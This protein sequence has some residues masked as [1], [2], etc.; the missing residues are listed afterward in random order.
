VTRSW[1]WQPN[2]RIKSKSFIAFKLGA[3]K[4]AV[5]RKVSPGSRGSFA[6]SVPKSEVLS[7]V[8][9]AAEADWTA[10]TWLHP[11]LQRICSHPPSFL[12]FRLDAL[13][14]Y[15]LLIKIVLV[16]PNSSPKLIYLMSTYTMDFSMDFS[17]QILHDFLVCPYNSRVSIFIK[18]S[19][20]TANVGL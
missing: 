12:R 5:E 10:S 20:L 1:N 14:S 2:C 11:L 3:G 9:Q 16:S 7:Q 8:L 19:S 17:I 4:I 15:D 13:I 18:S 6:T